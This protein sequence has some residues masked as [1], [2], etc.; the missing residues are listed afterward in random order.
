MKSLVVLK[1]DGS[2]F[3]DD[4]PANMC[5]GSKV[6]INKLAANGYFG[7]TYQWIW[8]KSQKG[9]YNLS[10]TAVAD[11][12][13]TFANGESFMINN[14]WKASTD[15][16]FRCAGEVDLL[17][18]HAV[19]YQK[20]LT[21]NTLPRV[22][23]LTEIVVLKNDKTP[24]SDDKPANMCGGSKIMI[25]KLGSNGYFGDTYQWIWN[26]SQKGWFDLSGTAVTKGTVTFAAGE[27][28]LI[29][30]IWKASTIVYLDLPDP[31]APV[32]AE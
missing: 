23:D 19:P 25:N 2:E 5:G 18:E 21:G 13:V 4:K 30:N 27:A 20:S 24:F 22:L 31:T 3:T 9:W 26:K 6:M 17:G 7:D 16:Y 15:I 28:M 12:Q 32:A 8:N 29:N 10:G 14:I 11:G 1:D